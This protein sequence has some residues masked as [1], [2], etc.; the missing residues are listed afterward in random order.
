MNFGNDDCG[1]PNEPISAT[2][3]KAPV[4]QTILRDCDYNAKMFNHQRRRFL[5]SISAKVLMTSVRPKWIFPKPK[6]KLN[7]PW[8]RTVPQPH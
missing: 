5:K 4:K 7:I 2:K 3:G 1:N 8:N 6:R